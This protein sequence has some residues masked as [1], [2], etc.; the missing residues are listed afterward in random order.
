MDHSKAIG[1][2]SCKGDKRN[3]TKSGSN[4]GIKVFHREA[5]NAI[6]F[7]G[8]GWMDGESGRFRQDGL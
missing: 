1:D 2:G 6:V 3:G 4:N 5:K 7:V 8:D